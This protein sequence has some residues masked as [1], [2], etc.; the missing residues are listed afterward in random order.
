MMDLHLKLMAMRNCKKFLVAFA[1]GE[2]SMVT[3]IFAFVPGQH[4]SGSMQI[5]GAYREVHQSDLSPAKARLFR[6]KKEENSVN[7]G[8]S[9]ILDVDWFS[10]DT[11]LYRLCMTRKLKKLLETTMGWVFVDGSLDAMC[12]QDDEYAPLVVPLHEAEAC[13]P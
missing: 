6:G 9:L 1:L 2:L 10:T 8:I 7:K 13:S 11:F 5:A 4:G 12:D 3:R